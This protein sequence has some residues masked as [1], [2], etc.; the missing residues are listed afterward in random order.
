ML[1]I[2][3]DAKRYF[4]NPTGLGNYSRSL[5]R[6]LARYHSAEVELHLYAARKNDQILRSD[7]Q[8]SQ[9]RLH[10]PAGML[11]GIGWRE[12]RVG[13]QVRDN[14]IQIFHGLS[15]ELP[16]GIEKK[17]PLAAVTIHD[18][19]AE[20]QPELF[21]TVDSRIYR[22]KMKS[23]VR[24]A[25]LVL[26]TSEATRQEILE[27][28]PTDPEKVQVLYQSPAE[29][30]FVGVPASELERVRLKYRLPQNYLL[31]VGTVIERKRL[32]ST[33]RALAH[34]D[35]RSESPVLVV[36]GGLR[37][38]YARRVQEEVRILGLHNRVLFHSDITSEDLP[39]VTQGATLSLYPSIYEGFGIPV[40]EALVSKVPVI[41]S[42]FSCLPEVAGPGAICVNP[43]DL[44]EYASAISLLLSDTP[45][46]AQI[47]ELG[48]RHASRSFLPA[49]LAQRLLQLYQK[50]MPRA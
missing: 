34:P 11:G 39:A 31:S 38:E 14:G 1:K 2:G 33:V 4:W 32:L 19:V 16:L 36:V 46:R 47:A 49:K 10:A 40:A 30:F 25:G 35:L 20:K 6:G 44:D 21:A 17:V 43:D 24:R 12:W 27:C 42:R 9:Y 41:T 50:R 5:I 7:P 26:A 18:L 8:A 28:Y 13:R 29:A 22:A 3:F 15:A 45:R 48:Q 23:A 37:S